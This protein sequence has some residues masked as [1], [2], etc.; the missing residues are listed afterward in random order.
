MVFPHGQFRSMS[1]KF[2]QGEADGIL[3]GLI[4]RPVREAGDI[5]RLLRGY[6]LREGGRMPSKAL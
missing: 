2:A 4:E 6:A 3:A 5:G 1:F